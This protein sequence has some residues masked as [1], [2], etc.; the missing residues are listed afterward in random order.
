MRR[1]VKYNHAE[2]VHCYGPPKHNEVE[3]ISTKQQDRKK[4]NNNIFTG[5]GDP[6]HGSRR[7]VEVG[8]ILTRSTK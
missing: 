7:S 1:K 5:G 2:V 8:I 4:D 6:Y 3:E